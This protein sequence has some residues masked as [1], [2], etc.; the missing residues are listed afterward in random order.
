MLK[1]LVMGIGVKACVEHLS[2]VLIFILATKLGCSCVNVNV[3]RFK[4]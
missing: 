4:L 2:H 1:I 3:A